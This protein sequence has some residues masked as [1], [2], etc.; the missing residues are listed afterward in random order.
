MR[1]KQEIRHERRLD[2]VWREL[3]EAGLRVLADIGIRPAVET[4]LLHP[5]QEVGRQIVPEPVALLHSSP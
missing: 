1:L 2:L 4:V 5:D 3:G